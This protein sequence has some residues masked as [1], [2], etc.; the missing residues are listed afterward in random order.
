MRPLPVVNRTAKRDRSF[1]DHYRSPR[2]VLRAKHV[3][4]PFMREWGYEFP[5]E[6]GD[7]VV[8]RW[9]QF[10][11]DFFNYFRNLYWKHLRYRI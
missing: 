10:R 3:F 5:T 2:V 4:G 7:I 11:F 8:S 6:W 9:D 1:F